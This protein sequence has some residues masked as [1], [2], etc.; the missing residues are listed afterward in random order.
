[1]IDQK[2]TI[3]L[4]TELLSLFLDKIKK[5]STKLMFF[6]SIDIYGDTNNTIRNPINEDFNGS[7]KINSKRAVYGE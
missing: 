5:T 4:N 1:M 3:F 7:I 2:S 6:S